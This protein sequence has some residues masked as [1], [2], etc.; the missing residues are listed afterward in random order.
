MAEIKEDRFKRLAEAASKQVFESS[1]PSLNRMLKTVD[2]AIQENLSA[3]ANVEKAMDEFEAGL[4]NMNSQLSAITEYMR[5]TVSLLKKVSEIID[6]NSGKSFLESL[7]SAKGVDPKAAAAVNPKS[8]LVAPAATLG[9]GAVLGGALASNLG[10]KDNNKKPVENGNGAPGNLLNLPTE[11]KNKLTQ[12]N[13]AQKTPMDVKPVDNKIAQ[14]PDNNQNQSKN[15]SS[16][17]PIQ[18]SQNESNVFKNLKPKY[19]VND[20]NKDATPL[21][22]LPSANAREVAFRPEDQN[23]TS[24][25]I[26]ALRE[27]KE[28]K[29]K[30]SII[31]FLAGSIVFND[32]SKKGGFSFDSLNT[33]KGSGA[34]S[35]ITPA[36]AG[37][38][39]GASGADG[40]KGNEKDEE[41]KSNPKLA[42][43]TTASGKKANVAKEYAD[44]FQGFI[45]DLEGTGY[46]I[47]DIGGYSFRKNVNNPSKMSMHSYGAAIDINPANNPNGT[48]KTDL[49]PETNEIAKKWGLGWGMNWKSVKDPMHFSAASQEGGSQAMGEPIKS[50]KS[51][52]VAEAPAPEQTQSSA[53]KPVA[54]APSASIGPQI[55]K[56]SVATSDSSTS[57]P[58]TTTTVNNVEAPIKGGPEQNPKLADSRIA[59]PV[60]PEDSSS[61]YSILFDMSGGSSLPATMNR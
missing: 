26:D 8:S 11:E 24:E 45:K 17:A 55:Q 14:L 51:S 33:E 9:G 16:P 57:A 27:S 48:T 41:L 13:D 40:S 6:K 29:Y 22:D 54:E 32:K 35:S 60:E 18:L 47:N 42:Q 15:S 25:S 3:S 4:D 5:K 7:F 50:T 31:E 19:D 58:P 36:G 37:G 56:S 61:R 28:T 34:G 52:S 59:G 53:G 39:G 43:V 49:P 30:A 44:K 23:K 10:G 46:K 12:N 2:D 20:L 21:A 1:F 38:G